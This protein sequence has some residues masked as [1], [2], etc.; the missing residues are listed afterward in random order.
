MIKKLV[1]YGNSHALVLDKALLE[2][3][4]ISDT[5]QLKLS[6]DG[7]GL[8]VTPI[9]QDSDS[10]KSISVSEH[11]TIEHYRNL[12]TEQIAEQNKQTWATM[13]PE[14]WRESQE[15]WNSIEKKYNYSER[16]R[17][18][19]NSHLFKEALIQLD[20]KARTEN[21]TADRYL[22]ELVKVQQSIA[23]DFPVTEI[24]KECAQFENK[25]KKKYQK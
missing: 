3:L 6:T 11:E 9:V 17:E 1:K 14:M 18:I 15:H 10:S 7:K 21:F 22:Q 23:P 20:Q 2:I 19:N 25:L 12:L 16:M 5:T 13:S 8:I 24:Q 4:N